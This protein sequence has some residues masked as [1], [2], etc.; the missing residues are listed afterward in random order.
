MFEN[1]SPA[2]YISFFR[3]HYV[4]VYIWGY[5]DNRDHVFHLISRKPIMYDGTIP[6]NLLKI[7][8]TYFELQ[9]ILLFNVTNSVNFLLGDFFC[10]LL[11]TA[12]PAYQ[13]TNYLSNQI[14]FKKSVLISVVLDL[15]QKMTLFSSRVTFE[16]AEIQ[17]SSPQKIEF[18]TFP[19]LFFKKK[20]HESV[21]KLHS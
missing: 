17:D 8:L 18:S 2:L 15:Y 20:S 12:H 4:F 1:L 10:F 21:R 6:R 11:W 13:Q 14:I 19:W 3:L 7:D 9:P 16:G 5:D